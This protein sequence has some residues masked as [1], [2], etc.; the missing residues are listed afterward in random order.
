MC[1]L[2]L[3]GVRKINED[4]VILTKYVLYKQ[5]PQITFYISPAPSCYV[6]N[7]QLWQEKDIL[8]SHW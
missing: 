3:S 7:H 6:S 4:I 8:S 2:S 5:P 1:C